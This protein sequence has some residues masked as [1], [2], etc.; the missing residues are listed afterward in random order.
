MKKRDSEI[1]AA[2]EKYGFDDVF[3]F[4]LPTTK[5][6]TLSL[7]NLIGKITDVYK[8]VEPEIIYMPF[9]QDVHT[10]HQIIANAIQSSIKWFRYPSIQK[11][12]MYETLSETNFNLSVS[13]LV[14]EAGSIQSVPVTLINST[15]EPVLHSSFTLFSALHPSFK[16]ES[17]SVSSTVF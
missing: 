4:S 8:K 1:N 15:G 17:I 13:S 6:D 14:V 10:D 7:S 3:K 5:I 11:V 16:K 12:L 9:A 2:A